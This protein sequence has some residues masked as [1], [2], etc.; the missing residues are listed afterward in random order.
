[1]WGSSFSRGGWFFGRF[2]CCT[3]F[4]PEIAHHPFAQSW[5]GA[6]FASGSVEIDYACSAWIVGREREDEK[7]T[8]TERMCKRV[9][10]WERE[11]EKKL[12]WEDQSEKYPRSHSQRLAL[13]FS[14]YLK[15]IHLRTAAIS[16]DPIHLRVPERRCPSWA[17]P[18]ISKPS[19]REWCHGNQ[20]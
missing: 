2:C 5:V 12:Y 19:H 9:S 10:E 18:G 7:E 16:V 8:K 14:T 3:A 6:S 4:W 1:M 20:K 17:A 15:P 13:K 11:R